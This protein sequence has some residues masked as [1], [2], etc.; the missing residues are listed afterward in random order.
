LHSVKLLPG[1]LY[2]PFDRQ[3][4]CTVRPNE[5]QL[6]PIVV[7]LIQRFGSAVNLNVHLHGLMLDGVYRVTDSGPVFQPVPAPTTEQL[8]TVHSRIITRLLKTLTRHGALMVDDT[9][10]PYLTGPEADPALAPLHAAACAYR[11]ALGPRRGQKVLTWKDPALHL[12][13]HE[14]P[15]AS[16]CVRAQGSV[17]MRRPGVE[18]TNS[19]NSNACVTT[20]RVR[21]WATNAS[22]APRRGRR[23]ATENP[24]RD[25]TTHL[26]MNP[27]EFPERLAALV[28]RPWLHLIRFHSV[29]APNVALRSQIVPGEADPAPTIANGDG[30]APPPPRGLG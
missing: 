25:G 15:E 1:L 3:S 20:S 14:T 7:T 24:H 6:S 12:T 21:P 11:I 30:E 22:A 18:P 19:R 17:Y 26:V 23:V 13:S 28:P 9:E 2:E 8:Q 10:I 16:G 5:L 29:L 4:R 27:L